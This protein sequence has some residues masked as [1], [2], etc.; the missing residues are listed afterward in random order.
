MKKKFECIK[1]TL[2]LSEEKELNLTFERQQEKNFYEI[3]KMSHLFLLE[4][5]FGKNIKSFCF[6]L[7]S[8]KFFKN[9]IEFPFKT[10]FK[11]KNP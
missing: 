9:I 4:K 10:G 7:K 5:L 11:D 8:L 1:F 6:S 3:L 2:I